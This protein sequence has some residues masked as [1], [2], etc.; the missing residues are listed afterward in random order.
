MHHFLKAAFSSFS[1]IWVNIHILQYYD[2]KL[3][4]YLILINFW[5]SLIWFRMF[6]TFIVLMI[7]IQCG[8]CEKVSPKPGLKI[9][10]ED[11]KSIDATCLAVWF[12]VRGSSRKDTRKSLS[13]YKNAF[14]D[15]IML[16]HFIRFKK[17]NLRNIHYHSF[18]HFLNFYYQKFCIHVYY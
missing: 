16:F 1:L 5:I 10:R 8:L 11:Y 12:V 15:L 2:F 3:R 4:P 17:M 18:Y 13:T 14:Y 6:L 9:F 7:T